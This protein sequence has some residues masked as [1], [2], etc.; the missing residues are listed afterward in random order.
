MR[1][2]TMRVLKM[3]QGYSI[4][5]KR[6]APEVHVPLGF[7]DTLEQ[8]ATLEQLAMHRA[9]AHVSNVVDDIAAGQPMNVLPGTALAV[10]LDR[11]FQTARALEPVTKDEV[12]ERKAV[13][14]RLLVDMQFSDVDDWC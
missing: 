6:P 11:L 1:K 14:E 8:C 4:Q 13:D 9:V 2:V 10:E 5:V 3:D 12:R 7:P